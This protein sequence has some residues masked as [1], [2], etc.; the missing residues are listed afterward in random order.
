MIEGMS[1]NTKQMWTIPG[2][3][4]ARIGFTSW[5][6]GDIARDRLNWKGQNTATCTAYEMYTLNPHGAALAYL[7]KNFNEKERITELEK[8][9]F[10]SQEE[11]EGWKSAKL[12]YDKSAAEKTDYSK[13]FMAKVL[14]GKKIPELYL[15]DE[16]C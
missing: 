3:G 1:W 6:K 11:I 10:Y 2:S 9:K 14:A 5:F 4:G 13:N 7:H 8:N 15:K 12:T 16:T